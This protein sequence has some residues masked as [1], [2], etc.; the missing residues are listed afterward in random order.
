MYR[1]IKGQILKKEGLKMSS[2]LLGL[3]TKSSANCVQ[4][5][6]FVKADRKWLKITS[7]LCKDK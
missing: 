3:L 5:G 7:S 2:E 6:H 4:H 1:L